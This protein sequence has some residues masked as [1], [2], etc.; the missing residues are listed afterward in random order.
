MT[1][2]AP[3]YRVLV[4]GSRDW[5]DTAWVYAALSAEASK[6]AV[7]DRRLVIVHGRCKTGADA[8]ADRWA[9]TNRY[10]I[11]QHPAQWRANGIYN[12][13]AGFLRNRQMVDLGADICLAFIRN[14]SRGATHCADL[15]KAA[16]IPVG[17]H[18]D[19]TP[20]PDGPPPKSYVGL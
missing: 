17:L 2:E 5:T 16:G 9:Y 20:K 3:A 8:I 19:S 10:G 18:L 15:A 12:P 1:D 6:A 7:Q 4:T 13:Q 14:G 11:E